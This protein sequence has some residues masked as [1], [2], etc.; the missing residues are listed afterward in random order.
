[1]DDNVYPWDFG[2]MNLNK[3]LKDNEGSFREILREQVDWRQ[4]LKEQLKNKK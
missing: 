1:M 2:Q 3:K 4:N